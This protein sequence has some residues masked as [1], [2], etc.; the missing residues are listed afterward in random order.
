VAQ[1]VN[2]S[3]INAIGVTLQR[4]EKT[5]QEKIGRG[6]E[7]TNVLLI[8]S[9]FLMVRVAAAVK[10]ARIARPKRLADKIPD[11]TS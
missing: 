1:A 5:R 10:V 4:Q 9:T 6:T 2:I 3:R 7:N 8:A 11:K